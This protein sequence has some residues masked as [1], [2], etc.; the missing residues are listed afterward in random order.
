M[1]EVKRRQVLADSDTRCQTLTAK[2]AKTILRLELA[3]FSLLEAVTD[4]EIASSR[5]QRNRIAKTCKGS[6]DNLV[7][8]KASKTTSFFHLQQQTEKST[9]LVD[10]LYEL[11]RLKLRN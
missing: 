8:L 3:N 9:M 6:T 1:M 5:S 2:L 10:Y 7:L 4:K 11:Y